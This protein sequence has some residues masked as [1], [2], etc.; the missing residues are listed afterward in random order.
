MR[1][2]HSYLLFSTYEAFPKELNQL[3]YAQSSE[4]VGLM[5]QLKS[6]FS[7]LNTNLHCTLKLPVELKL[8]YLLGT[9]YLTQ[10]YLSTV[11]GI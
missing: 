11:I 3:G 2:A 10:F 8:K 4:N 7:L 6:G 9:C 1:M 5:W